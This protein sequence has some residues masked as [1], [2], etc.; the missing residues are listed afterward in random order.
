MT[1]YDAGEVATIVGA[2]LAAALFVGGVGDG[3]C[4]GLLG[5]SRASTSR[6]RST[7]RASR[8]S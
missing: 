4:L 3:H 2:I 1:L 8:S 5:G 7:V 6:L